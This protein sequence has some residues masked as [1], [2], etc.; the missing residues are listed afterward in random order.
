MWISE[1]AD[2]KSAN[3]EGRLYS[4]LLVNSYKVVGKICTHKSV[5][6]TQQTWMKSNKK[7]E[8]S[9]AKRIIL[10]SNIRI[11]SFQLIVC[12]PNMDEKLPKKL[13]SADVMKPV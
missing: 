4:N 7:A 11:N 5:W 6:R 8:Y 1:F 13:S 3:N 2:K 12:T 9:F 10:L